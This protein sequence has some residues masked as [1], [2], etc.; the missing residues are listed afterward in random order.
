MRSVVTGTLGVLAAFLFTVSSHADDRIVLQLE[1]NASRVGLSCQVVEYTGREITVLTRQGKRA[2]PAAQVIEVKTTNTAP[3]EQGRKLFAEGRIA[4]ARAQFEEALKAEERG[5]VRR[6]ILSQLVRCA[7]RAGDYGSAARRFLLIA[8]SDPDT[9]YFHLIP[10]MWAPRV[11]DPSLEAEARDWLTKPIPAARLLAASYLLNDPYQ[12]QAAE[13]E[14]KALRSSP[15]RPVQQMAQTQLWRL[16]L[17]TADVSV[18]EIQRWENQ[19]EALPE[20]LRGGP[21]YLLG[22]AHLTRGEYES[23]ATALL[24]LPLVYDHDHFLAGRACFEAAVALQRIGQVQQ[25][26]TL[27]EEVATRFGKT[28]YAREAMQEL[29][30][31]GIHPVN[32]STGAQH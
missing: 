15:S 18:L 11:L 20:L 10:L 13:T 19:I 31:H 29:K 3:H 22:Q 1:G 21:Y 27:F 5:W 23:A 30:Q 16:R 8:Q 25:S 32:S 7:L 28:S 4:E 24:W 26:N 17:R 2:Y 12:G 14:L 6:E 9:I